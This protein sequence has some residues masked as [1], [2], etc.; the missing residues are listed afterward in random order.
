MELLNLAKVVINY[1]AKDVQALVLI[2]VNA[3]AGVKNVIQVV[4]HVLGL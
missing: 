3:K 1:V 4:Y 2:N